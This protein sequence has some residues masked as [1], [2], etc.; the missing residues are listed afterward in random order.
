MMNILLLLLAAFSTGDA[1]LPKPST[2]QS[3]RLQVSQFFDGILTPA[4]KTTK[5]ERDARI[6]AFVE[7]ARS[8]GPV[9][10]FCT[11]EQ[12]EELLQEARAL[13]PLSDPFPAKKPLFGFHDLVYS[14]AP[15][16]SSGKIGPF[17]GK[18][19]QEFTDDATFF[20]SVQLGPLQIALRAERTILDKKRIRV[21][22]RETTVSLL[23]NPL[24]SKEITNSGGVWN[25]IFAGEITQEDG[26]RKLIRVMET[27]S[28]FII[29]QDL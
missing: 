24:S 27:P 22:F 10:V 26:R 14:A 18:V 19:R 9:G 5:E 4:T 13:A 2:Q 20:N 28:L 17:A 11:E 7:K 29:E 25:Y 16:G 6:L 15:G 3:V 1:F 12:Q 21:T 23:G 8:L